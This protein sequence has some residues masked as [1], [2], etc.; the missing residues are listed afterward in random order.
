MKFTFN[1]DSTANLDLKYKK[2]LKKLH[3][4][5]GT[6]SNVVYG[7]CFGLVVFIRNH[8]G[9]IFPVPT[10]NL[11]IQ[12]DRSPVLGHLRAV[13]SHCLVLWAYG[14]LFLRK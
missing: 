5:A 7:F 9:F 8:V 10:R 6:V 12:G 3:F 13:P 14:N 11:F 4:V 1:L 2:K